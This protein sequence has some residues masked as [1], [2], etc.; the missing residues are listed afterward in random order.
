MMIF[1]KKL[2]IKHIDY[3]PGAICVPG[4]FLINLSPYDFLGRAPHHD[5]CTAYT[6]VIEPLEKSTA[7]PL[8]IFTNYYL[9]PV[10][11]ALTGAV[12]TG[13]GLNSGSSGK[14]KMW[15]KHFI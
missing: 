11:G 15:C 1:I 13:G 7:Y 9:S 12:P 5:D 10:G 4:K 3:L 14:V 6:N 8:Q 2:E